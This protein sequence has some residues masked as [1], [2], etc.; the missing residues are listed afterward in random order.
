MNRIE[1]SSLQEIRNASPFAYQR[2]PNYDEVK[3]KDT[4]QLA[5]SLYNVISERLLTLDPL[6]KWDLHTLRMKS[7]YCLSLDS[8]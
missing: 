2:M 5:M 8:C 6:A 1:S 3:N 7:F 4:E